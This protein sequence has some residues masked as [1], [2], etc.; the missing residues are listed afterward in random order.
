M[1]RIGRPADA[2]LDGT[3]ILI[4][5]VGGS[6]NRRYFSGKYRRHG[7]NAQVIT[8]P[9]GRLRWVPPAL[10]GSVHDLKAARTHGIIE[11]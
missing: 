9:H 4:D 5:R 2:I 10:P 3:L 11:A 8:D 1:R 7:L 6:A